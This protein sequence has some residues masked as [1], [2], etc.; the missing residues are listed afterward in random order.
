MAMMISDRGGIKV[1]GSNVTQAISK[2]RLRATAS[3]APD[4]IT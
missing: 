4:L 2:L 3:G 1:R